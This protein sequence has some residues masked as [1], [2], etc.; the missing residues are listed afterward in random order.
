MQAQPFLRRIFFFVLL[1][2]L[3]YATCPVVSAQSLSLDDPAPMHAG[4]NTATIDSMG[5]NQFWVMTAGPGAFKVMFH[6]GNRQEGFN[7]GG[8]PQM[9]VGFKPKVAGTTLTHADFPG[10]TTWE[11]TAAQASR[12]VVAVVPAPGALVRQTTAYTLE[13]T[14]TVSFASEAA[15]G[16]SVVGIYAIS[17]GGHEGTAK[18]ATDGQ[19]TT[20]TD[21]TGTWKLFDADSKS[22]V[23]VFAGKRYSVTY[24]PGRGFVDNGGMLVFTQKK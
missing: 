13:A 9:F 7:T 19:I 3:A 4:S 16:P 24:Q 12:V 11:G 22:Y 6:Y 15:A 20:T 17:I 21:E 14:G 2:G 8:R 23:I 5:G 1:T 18:F 10:G